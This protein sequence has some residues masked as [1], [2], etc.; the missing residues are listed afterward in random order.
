MVELTFDSKILKLLLNSFT[1]LVIRKQLKKYYICRWY[2]QAEPKINIHIYL[3]KKNK[4]NVLFLIYDYSKGKEMSWS[5]RFSLLFPIL[6]QWDPCSMSLGPSHRPSCVFCFLSS[7]DTSS[8]LLLP[9][10]SQIWFTKYS[11]VSRRKR[12]RKGGLFLLIFSKGCCFLPSLKRDNNKN[13]TNKSNSHFCKFPECSLTNLA[14]IPAG[15]RSN[16]SSII[17]W[18]AQGKDWEKNLH[19]SSVAANTRNERGRGLCKMSIRN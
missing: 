4:I 5:K 3:N 14:N 10:K 8:V 18:V 12:R 7:W 13:K 6:S 2:M 17:A 11:K 1:A 9:S 16:D 19:F 15:N